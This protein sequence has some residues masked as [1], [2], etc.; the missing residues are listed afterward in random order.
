MGVGAQAILH[1][2]DDVLEV[3]ADAVHLVDERDAGT[4]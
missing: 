2:P 3:G 1:H 4:P